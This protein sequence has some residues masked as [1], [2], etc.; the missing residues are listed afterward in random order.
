MRTCQGESCVQL[1]DLPSQ[2]YFFMFCHENMYQT[3]AQTSIVFFGIH[4]RG[5]STQLSDCTP[6]FLSN[7]AYYASNGDLHR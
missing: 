6:L 4:D 7:T 5:V 2:F 3:K 1:S